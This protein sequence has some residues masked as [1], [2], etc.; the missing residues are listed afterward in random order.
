MSL[1]NSL[2]NCANENALSDLQTAIF[3]AHASAMGAFSN[4]M[5]NLAGIKDEEYREKTR[6]KIDAI[7]NQIEQDTT[8]AIGAIASRTRQ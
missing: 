4:V 2:S 8:E 1:A 5:I 7:Q 6:S 3:L